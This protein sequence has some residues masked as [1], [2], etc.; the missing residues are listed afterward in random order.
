M[1]GKTPTAP[2]SN[3]FRGIKALSSAPQSSQKTGFCKLNLTHVNGI[4]SKNNSSID[5]NLVNSNLA[6]ITGSIV[7]IYDT[8]MRKQMHFL[9]NKNS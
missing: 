4:T 7:V 6:Y 3:N 5:Y 9:M 1:K 8:K 2:R